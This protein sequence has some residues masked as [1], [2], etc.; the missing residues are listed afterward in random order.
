[1][2]P[3]RGKIAGVPRLSGGERRAQIRA[4]LDRGYET[5]K[6]IA[7]YLG[8][9]VQTVMQY[10]H[11]MADVTIVREYRERKCVAVYLRLEIET[12]GLH[13]RRVTRA[14]A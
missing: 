14:A 9:S 1:M 13:D 11:G 10:A 4:A 5:P 12:A 8:L 2:K 3:P 7:A 6:G